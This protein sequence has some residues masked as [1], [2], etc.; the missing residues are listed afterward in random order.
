MTLPFHVC[1]NTME[2]VCSLLC[3]SI[4]TIGTFLS[5]IYDFNKTIPNV[6]LVISLNDE[7]FLRINILIITSSLI[8][9]KLKQDVEF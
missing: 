1:F 3:I 5:I 6:N 2:I 9:Y 8:Y 4:L 7:G